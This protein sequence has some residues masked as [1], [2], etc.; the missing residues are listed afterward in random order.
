MKKVIIGVIILVV[1]IVLVIVSVVVMDNRGEYR[2]T[3]IQT[4][5]F[6]RHV[7]STIECRIKGKKLIESKLIYEYPSEMEAIAAF[8]K[9]DDPKG[10]RDGTRLTYPSMMEGEKFNKSQ[11]QFKKDFRQLY[12]K[13]G[14][15]VKIEKIK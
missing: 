10:S 4:E 15:T 12:E 9:F 11:R 2:L 5:M 14:Y 3:A 1:I 7:V 8:K 6:D 13:Q